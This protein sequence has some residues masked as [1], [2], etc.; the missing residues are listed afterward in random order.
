MTLGLKMAYS[1]N[2]DAATGDFYPYMFMTEFLIDFVPD[3]TNIEIFGQA[4]DDQK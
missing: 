3:D 1:T 2:L 4:T